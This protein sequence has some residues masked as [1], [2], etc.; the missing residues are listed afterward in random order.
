MKYDDYVI[1]HEDDPDLDTIKVKLPPLPPLDQIDGH[2]LRKKDQK[3]TPVVIP[4]GVNYLSNRFTSLQDI[5]LA[6]NKRP[7]LYK[8]ELRF[9][10]REWA[11]VM[12]GYWF[13]NNGKPTWITGAHYLY[14][15]YWK[16][17][18][19][20]PAYRSRDR[21]F[22]IFAWFCENDTTTPE[23]IEMGRRLCLGFNYPKFR[24][25]GATYKAGLLNFYK[26]F[27]NLNFHG[28]I[29]SMDGQSAKK[30]FLKAVVKP[31]RKLP[32]FFKPLYGGS[33]S[34]QTVLEFDVPVERIGRSGS[35]LISATGLE[36]FIDYAESSKRGAY[37]GDK[38]HFYHRDE[39]G[40][41]TEEDV[42]EA[43]SVV[44]KCIST[45]NGVVVWGFMIYTSTVGQMKGGGGKSFFE[46]CKKSHYSKRTETGQTKSGLYNLF[47]SSYDGLEGFIDDYGDSIIEDPPESV[48]GI[49]NT[50]IRD[51]NGKLM[52]AKRYLQSTRDALIEE[53]TPEAMNDYE[54]EV[55]MFPIYF[56]ESFSTE[57]SV[58]GFNIM[59]LK[60]RE[61]ELMFNEKTERYDLKWANDVQDSEVIAVPNPTGR[62]SVSELPPSHIRNKRFAKQIIDY[63]GEMKTVFFP[64]YPLY[65]TACADPFKFSVTE[66]GRGSNGGGALLRNRDQ[67]I[68]EPNKS[69]VD[70][71]TYKFHMTYNHRTM[72]P[73][74]FAEDML[75]MCVFSSALMFPEINVPNIWDYF[76]RRHYDG[77][78]LY[79][80]DPAGKYRKTPGFNSQTA[81][82]QA[83]FNKYKQYIEQRIH[84]ED[85]LEL[86]QELIKINTLKDMT[87]YD[88]FTAGGGALLGAESDYAKF[89]SGEFGLGDSD[90]GIDVDDYFE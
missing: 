12:D 64:S 23:G 9:I 21:K 8:D 77:F 50:P 81:S 42:N 31:W 14:L 61:R 36:S 24:R 66:G 22:F 48:V 89:I 37:D 5:K 18:I 85:H 3:F 60:G 86:I 45:G 56:R 83:L 28:G 84:K 6:M 67:L 78:L 46:L 2:K 27:Q 52:G 73:D 17:D 7:D 79:G 59:K 72:T 54:E 16:I 20:L 90:F 33:T 82:K 88:L 13:Y 51:V 63:D 19:G 69:V 11:R 30:A 40:K 47:I 15:N 76:K 58:S 68:D 43:H 38:L 87:H 44:K 41:T 62:F 53:G 34:P 80:R 32:F 57:G 49:W 35:K 25:E 74:E 39:S 4:E 55:R 29:Q 65:Y 26:I 70:W 71:E 75:M 1:Y 10:T